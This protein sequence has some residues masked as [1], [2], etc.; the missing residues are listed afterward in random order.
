LTTAAPASDWNSSNRL[1]QSRLALFSLP[2]ILCLTE[3]NKIWLFLELHH[4]PNHTQ[5]CFLV[6]G[7]TCYLCCMSWSLVWAC[8]SIVW[9]CV[10][11]FTPFLIALARHTYCKSC[12]ERMSD[13][14]CP[15]CR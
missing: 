10:L 1:R 2:S 8:N 6:F 3:I 12:L 7:T 9:V 4:A 13:Q 14:R 5:Y 15:Q 11:V